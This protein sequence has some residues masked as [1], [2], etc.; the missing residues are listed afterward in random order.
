MGERNAY[1]YLVSGNRREVR[2][3]YGTVLAEATLEDGEWEI[4]Y[5]LV[6]RTETDWKAIEHYFSDLF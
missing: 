3:R 1:K 5:P 6:I 2:N 4:F